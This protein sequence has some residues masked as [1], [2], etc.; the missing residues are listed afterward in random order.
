MRGLLSLLAKHITL[1][2]WGDYAKEFSDIS[3]GDSVKATCLIRSEP[4]GKTL[5]TTH[6]TIIEYTRTKGPFLNT[7]LPVHPDFPDV[8]VEEKYPETQVMK[9]AKCEVAPHAPEGDCIET[10]TLGGRERKLGEAVLSEL[11]GQSVKI[12]PNSGIAAV[13]DIPGVSTVSGT[14][15][16]SKSGI[17]IVEKKMGNSQYSPDILLRRDTQSQEE[18]KSSSSTLTP[19]GKVR[20][21]TAPVSSSPDYFSELEAYRTDVEMEDPKDDYVT[22]STPPRQPGEPAPHN[23]YRVDREKEFRRQTMS[24][25]RR[26]VPR[27]GIW[28]VLSIPLKSIKY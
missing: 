13:D 7:I 27:S 17:T 14:P 16:G 1:M 4:N 23:P 10:P 19:Q 20:Y 18:T 6:E 21:E 3:A 11:K 8:F 5:W 25:L 9:S 24:V 26:S 2:M 12:R 15:S 22:Y 28:K